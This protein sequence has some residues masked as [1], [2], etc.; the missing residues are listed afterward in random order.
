MFSG[1]HC[2]AKIHALH[3][4]IPTWGSAEPSSK[5]RHAVWLKKEGCLV[6]P[7]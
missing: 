6:G 2:H 5:H 1:A 4:A 3:P 7:Q